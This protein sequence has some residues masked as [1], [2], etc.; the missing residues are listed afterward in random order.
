MPDAPGW[1]ETLIKV[2]NAPESPELVESY[3]R[4]V[5]ESIWG[6]DAWTTALVSAINP[7]NT[8]KYYSQHLPKPVASRPRRRRRA[9]AAATR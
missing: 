5:R 4:K 2:L 9:P 7:E 3:A 8:A 1:E 6:E